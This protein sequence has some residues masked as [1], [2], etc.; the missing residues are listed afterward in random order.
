MLVNA[1]HGFKNLVLGIL[2]TCRS[3]ADEEIAEALSTPELKVTA[4][5]VRNAID[6]LRES[7]SLPVIYALAGYGLDLKYARK[8]PAGKRTLLCENCGQMLSWVPCMKCQLPKHRFNNLPPECPE[9]PVAP[10]TLFFPGTPEKIE[11]MCRRVR[12]GYSCFNRLD[13]INSEH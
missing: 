5:Q 9:L 12:E 13:R 7:C 6:Q 3:L 1:L 8:L 10:P 4:T 2:I 11:V